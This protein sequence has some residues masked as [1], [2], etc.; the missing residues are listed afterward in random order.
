[1]AGES[2]KNSKNLVEG[3]I[4]ES[5]VRMTTPM[6]IGM[7]LLFTFSLVDTWFISFLGTEP[8]TAISF[9]FPVTFTVISLAI[10]L[11]IGASAVVASYLGA[12]Q[13]SKAKE[14]ATVINYISLGLACLIVTICWTLMDEIF[15]LIG[16]SEGLIPLI[17][18]YMNIWFPGSVLIVCIMTGNS[19]LRAYGDTKTPS[20][21]M[22]A[23]G[24][25]NATLDPLL[26]FGIGPFPELGIQG[27]A[28]ATIISWSASFCYLSYLLVFKLEMV[29]KS[30]PSAS[31]ISSSGK[32]MLR[33][34]IP[35]AGANMM[36]P[37]A[38]G[39][40]TAIAASFGDSAVAAFGVGARIEPI[41]T[42]LVLALS[43]SL[44]PLV[45]QNYGANRLDRVEEAYRISIK[46]IIGWQLLIYAILAICA[47]F[48][49][50]IFSNDQQVIASIKLFIWIMPLGYG[51]QGI[52]ILTNSSLNA[53]HRPLSALYLS[54]TRFFLFYVPLAYL[55]SV[56]FGLFG[57]FAGAVS[58]NLLMAM[59]SW[60]TLNQAVFR[61]L[62]LK[63]K[64]A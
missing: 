10:G 1:M 27:A 11:G 3:S 39:I 44:P 24:F 55:G 25:I 53:L 9:T 48:I 50:S 58:G 7:L 15:V 12:S 47:E 26:I 57:F 62:E 54:I 21:I 64:T 30:L 42:L 17:Q 31:V 4:Q 59:I 37:L 38:A 5:L 61:E 51:L 33:I 36:T 34:G 6:I 46:F 52:I 56:Y 28:W 49:A 40:M 60:R 16:A 13:V 32:D 2:K 22:A 18:E 23:A 29:S 35:A 8:L 14:A 63:E 19:L 45:S 20:I 43:S 41:A